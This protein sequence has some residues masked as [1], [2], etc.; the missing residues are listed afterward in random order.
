MNIPDPQGLHH[1]PSIPDDLEQCVSEVHRVLRPS[2]KF[3]MVEPRNT[4]FLQFAHQIV[5]IYPLRAVPKIDALQVMIER[6]AATYF[7]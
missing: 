2:G 7:E 4:P 6:E 1:L 5:R 3:V